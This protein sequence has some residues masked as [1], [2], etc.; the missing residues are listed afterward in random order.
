M[1]FLL[2]AQ[3]RNNKNQ[4]HKNSTKKRSKLKLNTMLPKKY[5][6][7]LKTDLFHNNILEVS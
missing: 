3:K 2:S 6:Q 4:A 7:I 5:K 1:L